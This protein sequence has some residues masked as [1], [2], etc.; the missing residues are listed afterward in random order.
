MTEFDNSKR[1]SSDQLLDELAV[2]DDL[3]IVQDL[4]GVCMQLVNDPLTRQ[5]D[6][7]YV[8]AAAQLGDTFAVLT[9]G[10]HEGRRG[11]NR[12]VEQAFGGDPDPAHAGLYLR[13]LAAGGVQFQDR[14]GHLSHPGVSEAEIAFLAGAPSRMEA[15][16]KDGLPEIFPQY[17]LEQIAQLAHAA[18]LDTQVSP[19]VNLNGIFAVIPD[20][21][22]KQRTMQTLLQRLMETLLADAV[23]QGLEGSFFLHVAPNLGRDE[24][25]H[26]R[27]KPAASGDVGTTDIQFMLS[28]SIKEAGLLV[29]LNQHMARRY[30]EVPFGDDFNVRVAPQNHDALLK[31]VQDRI[32]AERM[33]LL[34][35]VGD[36]VT[37]NPSAD[38]ATWLRGGSDRG[39]LTLLQ[40]LGAW[41]GKDN[42]VVLVDS[43]HGEVDRPSLSDPALTGISDPD[44]PLRIDVLMTAGPE[45]YINWFCQ[46]AAQRTSSP[47]TI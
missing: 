33:P 37:S 27:I 41:S 45:Q 3:L 19:T 29:L 6:G 7:A 32:P 42:R 43:S 17:S 47:A 13:G 10:E 38:G 8:M 21:V 36:T 40:A 18:V 24:Q 2:A 14:H 22:E 16:L 35:G 20:D 28:G 30:G 5:M 44:D 4:D 1:I 25:G 34:V 26:E 46:L 9:N 11:V 39:F 15:L 12:L 31:L 23:Q